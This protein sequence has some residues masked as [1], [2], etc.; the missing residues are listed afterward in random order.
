MHDTIK[1]IAIYLPQYH[2]IPENDA[3]WGEGFTE[4]TNVK[5]AQPLFEGHYQPHIPHEDVGYYDLREPETLVRQA[6][7]AKKYGIYGF[8][9]YHYWFNGKLLLNTPLD[10]MLKLKKPDF[11]FLYIWANE[12]WTRRWDGCDNEIIV[13]QKYSLEDDRAHIRYLCE[14]IFC[15]ERYIKINN[16]PIFAVYRPELFPNAKRTASLWREETAKYGFNGIYLI[17][18]NSVCHFPYSISSEIGFD[19]ALEFAPQTNN[20]HLIKNTYKYKDK[21]NDK[22]YCMCDYNNVVFNAIA[23]IERIKRFRCICPSWDNSARKQKTG[24][25]FMLTTPPYAPELFSYWFSKVIEYTEDNF[26]K[27]ERFV[28]INAWNEWGEG[29]HIEPDIKNGCKFLEAIEKTLHDEVTIPDNYIHYL[30]SYGINVIN[31]YDKQ[32][33]EIKNSLSY[34]TG[35]LIL[36]IPR[37]L[38]EALKNKRGNK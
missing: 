9:Y 21:G 33:L 22:E 3:A 24:G 10:N 30:E 26:P 8:A 29:C 34:K 35:R 11:P 19:T 12:N 14:T 4:W 38:K 5:T 37:I 36:T 7:M 27:N 25:S 31:E 32:I 15:D 13:K 6:A 16:K 18:V 17:N 1:L 23:D 20:S 2:P 28:F